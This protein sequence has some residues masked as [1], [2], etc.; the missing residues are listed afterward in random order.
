MFFILLVIFENR[1]KFT[2]YKEGFK[3]WLSNI[4]IYIKYNTKYKI[5]YERQEKWFDIAMN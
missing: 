3:I 1:Y 5:F 4:N 2:E